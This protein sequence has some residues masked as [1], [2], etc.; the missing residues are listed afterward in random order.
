MNLNKKNDNYTKGTGIKIEP[1]FDYMLNSKPSYSYE[2]G[3]ILPTE[4][5]AGTGNIVIKGRPGTGKSTLA[6]QIAV[7]TTEKRCDGNMFYSVYFT[8]EEKISHMMSKAELFGWGDQIKEL[9][10]MQDLEMNPQPDKLAKSL[11]K[12]LTQDEA[13]CKHCMKSN[14]NENDKHKKGRNELEGYYHECKS[15]NC[16]DIQKCEN[17]E[18]KVLL[19]ILSP[20]SIHK[21]TDS[22]QENLFWKR[23]SQIESFL[24]AAREIKEEN[25]ER[26]KRISDLRKY[27]ELAV[28][29][30]D[31][32]NVFGDKELSREELY[33]LFDLF[34]RYQVIGVMIYEEELSDENNLKDFSQMRNTIE[35]MADVVISLKVGQDKGYSNR[36]IEIEKSRYQK[37]IRGMHP[38]SIKALERTKEYREE[39]LVKSGEY[40]KLFNACKILKKTIIK[41]CR[42]QKNKNR[43]KAIDSK[44][45]SDII[46]YIKSLRLSEIT[47]KSLNKA[48]DNKNEEKGPGM[49][50]E[51]KVMEFTVAEMKTLINDLNQRI[52]DL[53]LDKMV[54]ESEY[55]KIEFYSQLLKNYTSSR[56]RCKNSNKGCELGCESCPLT[57]IWSIDDIFSIIS[58]KYYDLKDDQLVSKSPFV[59][60]PSLQSSYYELLK[61]PFE[62]M[63]DQDNKNTGMSKDEYAKGLGVKSLKYLLS[64]G[65]TDKHIIFILGE[66]NTYKTTLTRNLIFYSLLDDADFTASDPKKPKKPEKPKKG[67]NVVLIKFQDY[68]IMGRDIKISKDVEE[69]LKKGKSY[70]SGNKFGFKE[71]TN[72]ETDKE[73]YPLLKIL[74]NSRILKLN[75][76]KVKINFYHISINGSEPKKQDKKA[77]LM[78]IEVFDKSISSEELMVLI[79]SI[80]TAPELNDGEKTRIDRFILHDINHI[81]I[82][83]PLL[84]SSKTSNDLFLSSVTKLMRK[85]DV[86]LL[87]TAT[88]GTNLKTSNDLI[89]NAFAV[90]DSVLMCKHIEVFGS[91]YATIFS[92]NIMTGDRSNN[93]IVPG[94]I[95]YEN[96]SFDVDF[97]ILRGLVGF[98]TGKIYRP[99]LNI[100]L[101]KGNKYFKD[102]I[103]EITQMLEFGLAESMKRKAVMQRKDFS[104]NVIEVD[105]IG[106]E[107]LYEAISF[108]EG[109]PVNKTVLYSVDEFYLAEKKVTD[110]SKVMVYL[111]DYK[112]FGTPAQDSVGTSKSIKKI[113]NKDRYIIKKDINKKGIYNYLVPLYTNALYLLI[114]KECLKERHD[115]KEESSSRK[116]IQEMMESEKED[117]SSRESIQEIKESGKEDL[118]SWKIIHEIVKG[119]NNESELISFNHISKETISCVFIDL[120]LSTFLRYKE[121]STNKDEDKKV[122]RIGKLIKLLE[123]FLGINK[124]EDEK[125]DIYADFEAF[126]KVFSGFFKK[127]YNRKEDEN[128]NE[129]RKSRSP[130]K[131]VWHSHLREIFDSKEIDN[132]ITSSSS[133]NLNSIDDYEVIPLPGGGFVGDWY[134]GILKGSTN[135]HQGI[136]VIE[137]ICNEVEDY[138]RYTIGVGL[139][140]REKFYEHEYPIISSRVTKLS[141][142]NIYKSVY[143]KANK[144]SEIENYGAVREVMYEICCRY[145]MYDISSDNDKRMKELDDY[146]IKPL[147]TMLKA[148]DKNSEEKNPL[149]QVILLEDK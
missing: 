96:G 8:F 149:I 68:K 140:V 143:E 83:F 2:G 48:Y 85:Y 99:D 87:M 10:H 129:C 24:K 71:I 79:S 133:K 117:L 88:N 115:K 52:N 141:L 70:N 125:K 146:V 98:E 131:L 110:I 6:M 56:N 57:F 16:G 9:I 76:D 86:K 91:I 28:V 5:N 60:F 7:A 108:N 119:G 139:P 81:G 95:T 61:S 136:R 137:T 29:C 54:K 66:R 49:I 89:S 44:F 121:N 132:N 59:I 25:I 111:K 53:I 105:N 14:L 69:I 40:L 94:V 82:S 97:N 21:K 113:L 55:A 73:R 58:G 128:N 11:K 118:T 106:S 42:S 63:S 100:I 18:S 43:P 104:I 46:D 35:Y 93:E 34:K 4:D 51:E 65:L 123:D 26:G 84:V 77:C 19:P 114:D 112:R 107:A 135:I 109:G 74:D 13:V 124:K 144:R 142:K 62:T 103:K 120:I 90:S 36:Y 147:I 23:Y 126:H 138:K 39:F 22:E 148:F 41:D 67:E 45:E 64:D 50:E 75:N 37:Q 1:V 47:E 130:L 30:I 31:S 145:L 17:I 134:V 101:S 102:Y 33:R 20:R 38:Y 80:L 92:E 127:T 122:L 27:P 3:I 72:L 12:I 32:L 78:E 116:S 15:E